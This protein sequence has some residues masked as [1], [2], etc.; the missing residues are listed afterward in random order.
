M[1]KPLDYPSDEIVR[2]RD[3][4][5]REL[6]KRM[7]LKHPSGS[8]STESHEVALRQF[9][10]NRNKV[11]PSVAVPN[12]IYARLDY[13]QEQVRKGL[14]SPTRED[15]AA[16]HDGFKAVPVSPTWREVD[17]DK[18]PIMPRVLIGWNEV[19][20]PLVTRL[21]DGRWFWHD[22]LPPIPDV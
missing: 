8:P 13:I 14:P 18:M 3:T 1:T 9:I 10:E 12:F 11:L 6:D 22:P 7:D 17:L 2:Y 20:M 5:R 21:K 16:F 15:L 19:N 4:F